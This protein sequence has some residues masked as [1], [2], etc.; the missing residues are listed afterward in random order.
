[1]SS[2]RPTYD[3]E[4]ARNVTSTAQ[5][6][7]LA[8]KFAI[9]NLSEMREQ[10]LGTINYADGSIEAQTR[11]IAVLENAIERIPMASGDEQLQNLTQQA[12]TE[13]GAIIRTWQEAQHR[14]STSGQ[15]PE[16][17]LMALTQAFSVLALE[18]T[19]PVVSKEDSYDAMHHSAGD[20]KEAICEIANSRAKALGWGS[21][22][23]DNVAPAVIISVLADAYDPVCLTLSVVLNH[24][25]RTCEMARQSIEECPAGRL[26]DVVADWVSESLDQWSTLRTLISQL[27]LDAVTSA[28][29]ENF[30]RLL[31]SQAQHPQDLIEAAREHR[32]TATNAEEILP[33]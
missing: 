16:T 27:N 17:T 18:A 3:L 25:C 21:Q 23:P 24:Q 13:A 7:E 15:G 26:E 10:S 28:H 2:M 32:A 33:S 31:Q 22:L 19:I 1:M 12:H 9:T 14:E 4:T 6:V 20:F 11:A 8:L 5:S 30:S 29:V